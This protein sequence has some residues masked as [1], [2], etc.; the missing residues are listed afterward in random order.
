MI[1]FLLHKMM[2]PSQNS[3]LTS[4]IP[5]LEMGDERVWPTRLHDCVRGNLSHTVSIHYDVRF[6]RQ[7]SHVPAP[8]L[9]S[10]W[11]ME[12]LYFHQTKILPS[13]ATLVYVYCRNTQ[14]NKFQ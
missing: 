4:L 6:L 14:W 1:V 3:P 9:Q 11:H 2:R 7:A 5:L 13:P 12:A 8:E 10:D